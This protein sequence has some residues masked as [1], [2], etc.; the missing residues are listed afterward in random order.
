MIGL[1]T[2]SIRPLLPA[3]APKCGAIVAVTPLWQRYGLTGERAAGLLSAAATANEGVLVAELD[4]EVVGFAWWIPRGAFG[5]S[6]YLRLIGV[7]AEVRGHSVGKALLAAVEAGATLVGADC[8][9]LVSDFNHDAQRFYER[10][11]YSAIGRI[12]DFVA[13]GVTEII[14]RKVLRRLG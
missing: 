1:V 3:D 4:G 8:F 9:L 10:E 2:L 5:R 11:G 12:P 13:H 7:A 14:Y 6:P